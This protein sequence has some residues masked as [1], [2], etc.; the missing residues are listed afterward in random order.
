MTKHTVPTA[1]GWIYE[2]D[3]A[4]D[5]MASAADRDPRRWERG[6]DGRATA[7]FRANPNYVQSPVARMA[8]VAD[9]EFV[10][11]LA[12]LSRGEIRPDDF[13]ATFRLLDFEV[14]RSSADGFFVLDADAD[15]PRRLQVFSSVL[16]GPTSRQ[17]SGR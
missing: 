9:D 16:I 3:P 2:V 17:I 13:V 5:P 6:P 14:F 15:R 4:Y 1:G 11:L 10:A 7:A 8:E 12:G